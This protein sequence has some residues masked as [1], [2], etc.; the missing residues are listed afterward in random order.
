MT[1][2]AVK[3]VVA[4]PVEDRRRIVERKFGRHLGTLAP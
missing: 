3:I 1:G 4:Q 2:I